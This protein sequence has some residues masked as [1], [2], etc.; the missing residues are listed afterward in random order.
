MGSKQLI[1]HEFSRSS[2]S[3]P[4]D[5]NHHNQ[6]TDYKERDLICHSASQNLHNLV[7][8]NA[9]YRYHSHKDSGLMGSRDGVEKRDM[10]LV[11]DFYK[12]GT[13]TPPYFRDGISVSRSRN[14]TLDP[15]S[16]DYDWYS[17]DG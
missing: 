9:L 8:V 5:H 6:S 1:G 3:S 7:I 13:K 2:A 14:G 15:E 16:Y 4:E 17:F 10:I 11:R 12:A